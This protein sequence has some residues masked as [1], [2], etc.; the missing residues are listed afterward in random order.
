S[1][2]IDSKPIYNYRINPNSTMHSKITKPKLKKATHSR[3]IVASWFENMRQKYKDNDVLEQY[4]AHNRDIFLVRIMNNLQ[5]IGYS[6]DL[7]FSKS[8][9][10]RF[11]PYLIQIR[12]R[13]K[14]C[15][16][17]PRIYGFPKRVRLFITSLF[18]REKI[19]II[20]QI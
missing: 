17:F 1:I 19:D 11:L 6:K 14:F 4:F 5:T 12:K 8:E 13:N 2:Y 16:H 15:F 3:F 9:L 18:K 10:Q 7:G 20:H